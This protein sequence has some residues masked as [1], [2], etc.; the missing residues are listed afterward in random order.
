MKNAKVRDIL[1]IFRMIGLFGNRCMM[2][3]ESMNEIHF[4]TMAQVTPKGGSKLEGLNFGY[5]IV[6]YIL[7]HR[8]CDVMRSKL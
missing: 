5:V 3:D 6:Y 7:R 4:F 8:A 1:W 2:N